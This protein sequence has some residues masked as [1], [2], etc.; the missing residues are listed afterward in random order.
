M[1]PSP[2]S[3]FIKEFP[4]RRTKYL[5]RENLQMA[6]DQ[7]YR[8]IKCYLLQRALISGWKFTY[9]SI[10]GEEEQVVNSLLSCGLDEK[11]VKRV[12]NPL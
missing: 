7:L 10:N 12:V 8:H 1:T 5:V 4:S 11:V 2:D 3:L 9:H 6:K